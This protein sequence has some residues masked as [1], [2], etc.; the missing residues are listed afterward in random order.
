MQKK[1]RGVKNVWKFVPLRGGGVGPLMAKAILNFHFDFLHTSLNQNVS[2]NIQPLPLNSTDPSPFLASTIQN[3][4]L[5]SG[6]PFTLTLPPC[7]FSFHASLISSLTRRC[8]FASIDG[9]TA[10]FSRILFSSCF[11]T[12]LINPR[13]LTL[14]FW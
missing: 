12:F 4:S 3:P 7:L 2:L 8:F 10:A 13:W 11:E 5:L 9:A 1:K 6:P 14:N